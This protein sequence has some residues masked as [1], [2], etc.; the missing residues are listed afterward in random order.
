VKIQPAAAARIG[1]FARS[2]SWASAFS[3]AAKIRNSSFIGNS[4]RSEK[5][6]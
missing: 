4:V 1:G 2:K 6:T 5:S 3:R